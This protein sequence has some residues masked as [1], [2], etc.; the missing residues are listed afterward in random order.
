MAPTSSTNREN[1]SQNRTIICVFDPVTKVTHNLQAD[2][3]MSFTQIK[4]C[5]ADSNI[6]LASKQKLERL[7]F[8]GSNF[9]YLFNIGSYL[10]KDLPKDQYTYGGCSSSH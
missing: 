6:Y 4:V 1:C 10:Q 7:N 5:V 8:N 3:P 2:I 9:L